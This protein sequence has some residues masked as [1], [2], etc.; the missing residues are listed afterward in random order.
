MIPPSAGHR[1]RD[2]EHD[3]PDPGHVDPGATRC[4]GVSAHRVD[5]AAERRPA[6]EVQSRSG[7]TN[8][9]TP[10]SGTPR[11]GC[12]PY[13]ARNASTAEEDHLPVDDDRFP[14]AARRRRRL[15]N[16]PKDDERV[17]AAEHRR[18]DPAACLREE[19]VGDVVDLSCPGSR[20]RPAAE[21]LEDQALPGEQA[22][23]R[24]DEGRHAEERHERSLDAPIATP[25]SDRDR[26]SR[27]APGSRG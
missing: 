20:S 15:T 8:S 24:D 4:L 21:H 23:E 22:G 16:A 12:R 27:R 13:T 7:A 9:M 11:R 26:R 3:H 10:A 2:H 1:A 14:S 6:G 17:A 5:V 18:D 25:T 19:V